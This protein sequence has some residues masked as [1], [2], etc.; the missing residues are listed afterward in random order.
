M[1]PVV[2][3]SKYDSTDIKGFYVELK[4]KMGALCIVWTGL[5]YKVSVCRLLFVNMNE[6]DYQCCW[7]VVFTQLMS[8]VMRRSQDSAA[9][10]ELALVY[11]ISSLTAGCRFSLENVPC[12]LVKFIIYFV[13]AILFVYWDG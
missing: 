6:W 1:T 10:A 4:I 8:D 7:Y 12:L 9:A 3:V 11:C 5:C 2:V 13:I